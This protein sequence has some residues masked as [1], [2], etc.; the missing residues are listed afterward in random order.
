MSPGGNKIR[1]SEEVRDYCTIWSLSVIVRIGGWRQ[2]ETKFEMAQI[3]KRKSYIYEVSTLAFGIWHLAFG[4]WQE[5]RGK[6][7]GARGKRQEAR[8]KRREGE[9]L[10]LFFC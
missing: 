8:G 5:A 3:D 6:R 10:A 1:G 9:A 7:Q 4:I 2:R